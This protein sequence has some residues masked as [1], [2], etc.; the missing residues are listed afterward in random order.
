M[1]YTSATLS[2]AA[3]EVFVHLEVED[4]GTMFS[5]VRA[6]VPDDVKIDYL[7]SEQLPLNWRNHP[8]PSTLAAIGDR[9]FQS[10]EAAILAVPSAIIPV[11][12]NY[13]IDPMHPEFARF[14]LDLPQSFELDPRL[15]KLN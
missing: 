9:W 6:N 12:Y 5:F 2:L 10:R 3:L 14:E 4:A 11:E 8:A 13:L 1:V 7:R 15:W